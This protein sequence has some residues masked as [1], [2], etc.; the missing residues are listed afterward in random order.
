MTIIII[1][2]SSHCSST[3]PIKGGGTGGA[4][5]AILKLSER[6]YNHHRLQQSLFINP[7]LS[8]AAEPGGLGGL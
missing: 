2:Y 1:G 3:L 8:R 4:R 7:C 5:G 6:D